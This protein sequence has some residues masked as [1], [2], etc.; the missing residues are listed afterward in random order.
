MFHLSKIFVLGAACAT[1]V[2]LSY[3]NF[4]AP[5][6]ASGAVELV[7]LNSNSR[8]N[9]EEGLGNTARV[10]TPKHN[11]DKQQIS[12][13]P[14]DD[15]NLVGTYRTLG[16]A[17]FEISGDQQI[18]VGLG[19]EVIRGVILRKVQAVQVALELKG[20]A[21]YLPLSEGKAQS[22]HEKKSEFEI[23]AADIKSIRYANQNLAL[24]ENTAKVEIIV[25][26]SQHATNLRLEEKG[27]YLIE[28][29]RG[30]DRLF[31]TPAVELMLEK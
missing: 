13:Y 18:V 5:H 9:L 25:I 23:A 20:V 7:N 29:R 1:G 19:Q 2:L 16:M 31:A 3:S 30:K 28:H 27:R 26:G 17:I 11:F 22:E 8:S 14:G 6:P 4:L 10:N 24:V 21:F 15:I 12:I